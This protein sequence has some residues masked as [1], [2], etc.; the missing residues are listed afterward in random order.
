MKSHIISLTNYM[1]L[2]QEP[3]TEQMPRQE[4][5]ENVEREIQKLRMQSKKLEPVEI[6]ETGDVA[7][8]N[9]SSD[10]KKFDRESLKLNV[11]AG[12]FSK[13]LEA[14][15]PGRSVGD[16]YAAEVDG[17]AVQVTVAE[18]RRAVVPEF[19]DALA[20]AQ[21]IPGVTDME[22]YRKHVFDGYLEMFR[23]AY[24]E[25]RAGELMEQWF[26]QCQWELDEAEMAEL[27]SQW[28]RYEQESNELH[29][30]TV[31]ENYP[32][33]MEELYRTEVRTFV[34]AAL[35]DAFLSGQD[36]RTLELD[37][38]DTDRVTAARSRVLK[39]IEAY[40]APRF[41]LELTEEEDETEEEA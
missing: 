36:H 8:L 39:P 3:I 33:E 32:G 34:Q 24:L 30:V 26:S 11:G 22:T 16:S 15:L 21:E 12:L 5:L 4:L 28:K 29:N 13:A 10:L 41:T 17:H 2:P 23:D 18:C 20:A 40:I 37:I 19:S 35:L 6:V 25:Y 9:L 27:L 7:T 31:A 38:T 14:T 1:L